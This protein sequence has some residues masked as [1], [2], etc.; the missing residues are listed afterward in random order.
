MAVEGDGKAVHLILD[1][2]EEEKFLR[3][4]RQVH[5]FQRIS[6]EQFMGL[7]LIILLQT[8]QL[9]YPSPVLLG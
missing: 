1:A 4:A 2:L 3:I 6:K 9:E 8:L 7:V 5:H